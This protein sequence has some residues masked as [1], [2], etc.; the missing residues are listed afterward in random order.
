MA[1]FHMLVTAAH[2][3]SLKNG[4]YAKPLFFSKDLARLRAITA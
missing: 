3:I 1:A 4:S 2:L